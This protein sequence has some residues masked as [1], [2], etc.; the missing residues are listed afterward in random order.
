MDQRAFDAEVVRR[1]RSGEALEG[2]RRDRILLV[3]TSGRR[4]GALR[5]TPVMFVLDGGEPMIVASN[6]GAESHP[7]WFLDLQQEPAVVVETPDGRTTRSW[8]EALE[9]DDRERAWTALI[10]VAPFFAEHQGR[11]GGRRIPLVKLHP[12]E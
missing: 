5:T 2:V 4:S 7:G 6:D 11:T 8:A 10:T 9:G 12:A 3:T 1:F